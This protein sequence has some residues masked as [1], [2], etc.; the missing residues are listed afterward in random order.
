[1]VHAFEVWHF[2]VVVV[3]ALHAVVDAGLCRLH[4]VRIFVWIEVLV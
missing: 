3:D 2:V 4:K 1:V